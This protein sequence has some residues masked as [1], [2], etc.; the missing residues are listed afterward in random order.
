VSGV[1]DAVVGDVAVSDGDA[2][3]VGLG[4]A[5]GDRDGDND[6]DSRGVGVDVGAGWLAGGLLLMPPAGCA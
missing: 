2:V 4:S 5:D 6:G 1:V 3:A